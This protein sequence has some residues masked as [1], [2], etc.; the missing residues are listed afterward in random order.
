[1]PRL[2]PWVGTGGCGCGGMGGPQTAPFFVSEGQTNFW[3]SC[4]KSPN[5]WGWKKFKN[6]L[7]FTFFPSRLPIL[8]AG[9]L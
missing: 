5:H 6:I 3:A 8:S 9:S 1:M 7:M 2:E 4:F